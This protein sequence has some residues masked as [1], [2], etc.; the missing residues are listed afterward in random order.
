MRPRLAGLALLLPLTIGACTAEVPKSLCGM[1][2]GLQSWQGL[3]VRWSG[4]IISLS[5]PPDAGSSSYFANEACGQIV[6]IP[7]QGTAKPFE[8]SAYHAEVEGHLVVEDRRPMLI[9]DHYVS[10]V[11]ALSRA[12]SEAYFSR[13]IAAHNRRLAA[14][15][16][17]R[18]ARR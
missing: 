16:R 18:P 2:P 1:P 14:E 6:R 7:F 9:I 13:L 5:A 12:E 15:S 8:V 11:P 10:R 4:T 17:P 3:S